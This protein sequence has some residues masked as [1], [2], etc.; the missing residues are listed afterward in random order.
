[1][2]GTLYCFLWSVNG[3]KKLDVEALV[4]DYIPCISLNCMLVPV[5]WREFGHGLL[6]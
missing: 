3:S 6:A 2:E 5:Y 1:M 4:D